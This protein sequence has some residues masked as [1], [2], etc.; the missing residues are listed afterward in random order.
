LTWGV[1]LV[2]YLLSH[3]PR[4]LSVSSAVNPSGGGAGW[5]LYLVFLTEADDIF[6]ALWG[7]RFGRRRITPRISPN[8]S[9]EGLIGGVVSTLVLGLVLAPWLTPLAEPWSIGGSE[10]GLRIPCAGAVV[11]CLLISLAGFLGDL[12][13]SALKR[14]AGVKDTG[15]WLP[16]QGGLLDRVDSLTFTAPVFYYFVRILYE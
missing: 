7:R 13:M 2:V 11:A 1:G 14:D 5:F 10:V 3:A 15:S 4:L 16:S 6:Q 12:N 9:L 8:K